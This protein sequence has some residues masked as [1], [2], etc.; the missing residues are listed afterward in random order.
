MS[1][2]RAHSKITDIQVLRGISILAVLFHH[3]SLSAILL[4]KFPKQIN[5]P[6]YL[7]VELFFVISGYVVTMSLS[8]DNFNGLKF[9]VKRVFR[10]VPAIL[11]FLAACFLIMNHIRLSPAIPDPLKALFI[12]PEAAFFDQ[13]WG[14]LGA[15]FI[16]MDT[17]K[18]YMNGA[19]WSLSV[20]DQFYAAIA[21]LSLF[22]M[23]TRRL[24]R[25]P[26]KWWVV[27]VSASL[28]VLLFRMRVHILLSNHSHAKETGFVHYL[29]H[30]KFDFLPVGVLLA[31]FDLSF[32]GRVAKYLKDRGPAFTGYLFLLPC[33][34]VAICESAFEQHARM[35]TGVGLPFTL[36]CFA[37]LVLLAG[38]QCAF[39]QSHGRIY[40]FLEYMGNRSYTF[41]LFH[42]PIMVVAWIIIFRWVPWGLKSPIRYSAAQLGITI[43]LL[44]PLVEMIYRFVELPLTRFGKN[45][46]DGKRPK[47]AAAPAATD[48]PILAMPAAAESNPSAANAA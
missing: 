23:M 45:L 35:L 9:L 42:F 16:M 24:T 39:P 29:V 43:A 32:P 17:P 15:Y 46:V 40:R 18:S 11:L 14:I 6:F 10:L 2:N 22:A 47:P 25:V 20:E 34:V 8:K 12:I 48:I 41:Y 44:T 27:A 13:A 19:M 7:G 3:L 5:M 36:L 38:N 21:V 30:W 1:Q 33:A 31:M 4:G 28:F 26:A 37:L